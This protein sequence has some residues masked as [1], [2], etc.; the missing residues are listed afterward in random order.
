LA[1]PPVDQ[2][3]GISP[4]TTQPPTDLATWLE[5]E[6]AIMAEDWAE[7]QALVAQ[8]SPAADKM[9]ALST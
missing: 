2:N 3:A 6:Q 1:Q 4:T 7:M 8:L 5:I 9:A